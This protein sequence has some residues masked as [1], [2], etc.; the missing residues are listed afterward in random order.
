[1][2][3]PFLGLHDMLA[4]RSDS[5]TSPHYLIG[6]PQSTSAD[7]NPSENL[8]SHDRAGVAKPLFVGCSS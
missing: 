2:A 1:M 6:V 3:R 4:F 8:P 5:A 7:V